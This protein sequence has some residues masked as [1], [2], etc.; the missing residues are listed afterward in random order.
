MQ[1]KTT[2]RDVADLS[3]VSITTV[4]HV[5]NDV[6]G[7]RIAET[8]RQRVRAAAEELS[9]RPN[10]L[11]QGLRLRRSNTLGFISDNV[12]TSPYAGQVILGAQDAAAEHGA[13]LMLMSSGN[14]PRLEDREIR[15]LLDRQVDGILYATEYHRVITPPAALEDTRA[16]LLD[17]RSAGG[18]ITS[19][20]PD[21][22]GGAMT[23]VRELT[24]HGHQRIGFLNNVDDIP[25]TTL[26][27]QGFKQGLKLARRRFR[28]ALVVIEE[29]QARGGYRAATRLLG[30]PEPMRPTGLF[31]FNDR[32]A[33]GAYQAA[34]DLGLSIPQDLSIIGFD[35]QEL[36]AADVRPGL[37]T[38]ALP[39][40]EMGEWA[41]HALMDLVNSDGALSPT[42]NETIACPLVRRASVGPPPPQ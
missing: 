25:A 18:E 35:N 7:K 26:R 31:C 14:D 22:V 24:D 32:M 42:R 28:P 9:Y 33:M 29:S 39:H 3:G 8:T 13:M 15:A 10:R 23:A 12:A 17:A 5:L 4:S 27:L 36:I 11:A 40:Y 34:T 37:T 16:V 2:L 1:M 21:E 41:V 30:Q 20:V 38:V 6:A 19:V